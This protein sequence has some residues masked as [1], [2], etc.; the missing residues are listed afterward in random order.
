MDPG[1]AVEMIA[2][3]VEIRHRPRN[4]IGSV[5]VSGDGA[6]IALSSPRG[7]LVLGFDAASRRY[8]GSVELRD[9]CGL[10]PDGAGVLAT[11]G[12]GRMS[13][14]TN[15]GGVLVEAGAGDAALTFDNHLVRLA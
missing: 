15:V 8:L 3:P 7:G 11:A 5:A 2:L 10:A 14:I 4:Y 6:T 13:A 9:G 1:G 12:T